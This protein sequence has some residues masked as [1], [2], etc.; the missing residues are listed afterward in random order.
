MKQVPAEFL[1][2]KSQYQAETGQTAV[3][4]DFSSRRTSDKHQRRAYEELCEWL[5]AEGELL[6]AVFGIPESMP[7]I[8]RQTFKVIKIAC[9]DGILHS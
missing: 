5:N 2:T 3:R 6:A 8:R 7:P 1:L 4:G 9:G